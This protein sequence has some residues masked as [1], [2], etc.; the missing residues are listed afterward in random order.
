MGYLLTLFIL[1]SRNGSYFL[2]VCY[3]VVYCILS[4][5][6]FYM[7]TSVSPGYFSLLYCSFFTFMVFLFCLSHGLAAVVWLATGLAL[8]F[9]AIV[10]EIFCYLAVF[11]TVAVCFC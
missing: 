7:N 4:F 6:R 5:S 2:I 10:S 9:L 3:F 11:L 1:L 8:H